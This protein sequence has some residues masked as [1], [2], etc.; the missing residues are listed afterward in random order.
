MRLFYFHTKPPR[1]VEENSIRQYGATF[2]IPEETIAAI[3]WLQKQ[4]AWS[5]GPL[6]LSRFSSILRNTRSWPVLAGHGPCRGNDCGQFRRRHCGRHRRRCECKHR[7]F[8]DAEVG[9]YGT[10]RVLESG[11]CFVS[12]DDSEARF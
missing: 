1:L 4:F 9:R 6:V 12:G 3:S 10:L 11:A 2:A 5:K 8:A 7:H